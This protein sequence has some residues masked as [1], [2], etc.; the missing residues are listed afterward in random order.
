MASL[1]GQARGKSR[2]QLILSKRLKALDFVVPTTLEL[3]DEACAIVEAVFTDLVSTTEAYESL[4][5][6]EEQLQN[7]LSKAQAQVFPLRKENT[8]LLRENNQLHMELIK[9]EDS[10]SKNQQGHELEITR[11]EGRIKEAEFLGK[12]KDGSLSKARGENDHLKLQLKALLGGGGGAPSLRTTAEEEEN[13]NP[14]NSEFAAKDPDA[15]NLQASENLPPSPRRQRREGAGANSPGPAY[16]Q[17]VVEAMKQQLDEIKHRLELSEAECSRQKSACQS[18][19]KEVE[20]LSAL[21]EGGRD[22][23]RVNAEHEAAGNMRMLDQLNRQVD[24]LNGQLAQREGQMATLQNEVR[25]TQRAK[26]E[27]KQATVSARAAEEMNSKLSSQIAEL[28]EKLAKIEESNAALKKT[29]AQARKAAS[30]AAQ[31]AGLRDSGGSLPGSAGGRTPINSPRNSRSPSHSFNAPSVSTSHH[32]PTATPTST[33]TAATSAAITALQKEVTTLRI[34]LASSESEA[35]HLNADNDRLAA[36]L[37]IAKTQ[38]NVALSSTAEMGSTTNQI[39]A[40]LAKV[41]A[42]YSR[43]EQAR[44]RSEKDAAKLR[45]VA[46]R[47]TEE[48][49]SLQQLVSNLSAENDGGGA[50]VERLRGELH[51]LTSL[52]SAKDVDITNLTNAL[53]QAS[54]ELKETKRKMVDDKMELD[55]LRNKAGISQSE[56]ENVRYAAERHKTEAQEAAAMAGGARR[57]VEMERSVRQKLERELDDSKGKEKTMG[58]RVQ[59]LEELLGDA[60][61][62]LKGRERECV[63]LKER[64]MNMESLDPEGSARESSTLRKQLQNATARA[65]SAE[66]ELEGVGRERSRVTM[67]L[68]RAE[69]EVNVL[70]RDISIGKNEI[71]KL[72]DEAV[73]MRDTCDFLEQGKSRAEAEREHLRAMLSEESASVGVRTETAGNLEREREKLIGRIAEL[74]SMLDSERKRRTDS[75]GCMTLLQD[76]SSRMGVEL[77]K[78]QSAKADL[79]NRLSRVNNELGEARGV[80]ASMQGEIA[81]ARA[82]LGRERAARSAAEVREQQQAGTSREYQER[83]GQLKSLFGQLE[84]TRDGLLRKLELQGGEVASGAE[85]LEREAGRNKALNLKCVKLEQEKEVLHR[86]LEVMDSEKDS[87]ANKMDEMSDSVRMYKSSVDAAERKLGELEKMDVEVRDGKQAALKALDAREKEIVKLHAIVN[88]LQADCEELRRVCVAREREAERCNQDLVSMTR[89]AQAMGVESSRL[90]G[91]LTSTRKRLDEVSLKCAQIEHKCRAVELEKQDLLSAYRAVV[92][93]RGELE[94]GV[95][96]LG[97]ERSGLRTELA[98]NR[99]EV[100]RLSSV[101]GELEG[102]LR[103]KSGDMAAFE[104]QLDGISRSNLAIQRS[105][106]A[107][108]SENRRLKTDLYAARQSGGGLARHSSEL[109]RQAAEKSE[110]AGAMRSVVSALEAERDGLQR[111]LAEERNHGNGVETLLSGLRANLSASQEQVRLMAKENAGLQT[112]INGVNLKLK[113]REDMLEMMA[114]RGGG[115]EVEGGD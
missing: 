14:N 52:L 111:L 29:A 38:S 7:E 96:E 50:T 32:V 15:A 40:R 46:G 101:V 65:D 13:A 70:Q 67:Q 93:E 100:D 23:D 59:A 77:R 3:S 69:E 33:P 56:A 88:S 57:Q 34:A 11:L 97:A 27:A 1:A 75:D 64:L 9:A 48:I 106:E 112:Q 95:E 103:R 89:E 105:L 30:H 82:E 24:F 63:T 94:G 37:D 109:Q 102:E 55:E 87:L 85:R 110:E 114:K 31:Q 10:I 98:A 17:K 22:Y 73:G 78:L 2:R 80:V 107:A 28:S 66:S 99:G 45:E 42:D 113:E 84:R 39:K 68:R 26:A 35:T 71:L 36:A 74:E 49:A 62:R 21:L 58:K 8:R 5:G 115:E 44:D 91:E 79:E 72:R 104:R 6:K 81:G 76:D 47:M 25:Q 20:R 92:D 41:E 16:D 19:E 54:D 53:N 61:D 83:H 51:S 108:E 60:E 90:G 12:Q 18:R 86:N 43:S 4:Q